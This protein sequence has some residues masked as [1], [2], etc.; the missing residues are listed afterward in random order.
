[1]KGF[2]AAI[3]N[4]TWVNNDFRRVLYTGKHSQLVL[5]SLKPLEEIG[6]E[7]H[8]TVDQFFRFEEGEGKV[9]VDNNEYKVKDGDAVI[10]PSG[11][12]HNVINT[13]KTKNLKLYTIYSPPEHQDKVI[14][15]TKTDALAKPEEF[16]GKTTE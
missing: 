11:A 8:D 2:K 6:E 12:K 13:S 14:R 9:T 7:T 3:E 10:V 16:D 4:D 15:H 5:M 1:M